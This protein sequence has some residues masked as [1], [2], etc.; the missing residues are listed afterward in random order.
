MCGE[1]VTHPFQ[2]DA[3][4]TVFRYNPILKRAEFFG[5]GSAAWQP[6]GDMF[7]RAPAEKPLLQLRE[8]R[9]EGGTVTTYGKTYLDPLSE[10]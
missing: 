1:K 10:F 9:T 8:V 4:D 6:T 2:R 7:T 5:W 3:Y